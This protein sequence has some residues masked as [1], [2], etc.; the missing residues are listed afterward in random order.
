MLSLSIPEGTIPV[1]V[2]LWNGELLLPAHD[3]VASIL[4]R[5]R[6]ALEQI[7]RNPALGFSGA[8]VEGLIEIRGALV[9]ALCAVLETNLAQK[10]LSLLSRLGR[11]LTPNSV[12]QAR[13]NAIAHYDLGCDFF[14]LWLDETMTYSCAVFPQPEAPLAEAQRAKCDLICRKLALAPGERLL[15]VGCGWGYLGIH[16][17]R[18]YGVTTLGITQSPQQRDSAVRQSAEQGLA[19]LCRFELQDYRK[20]RGVFD[21]VASVGMLE[22]VGRRYLG[23]YFRAIAAALR[24]GGRFC[25]QVIGQLHP[26]AVTDFTNA[27]FPGGYIPTATEVLRHAA[28]AGLVCRHADNLAEHYVLTLRRWR[29]NFQ[30]AREKIEALKGAAFTRWWELHLAFSEAA[31]TVG[32]LHLFQFL[33]TKGRT[34]MPLNRGFAAF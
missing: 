17:A 30:T 2:R 14:R 1:E 28:E 25:L 8:Y 12:T 26:V 22:H 10:G 34:C 4:I 31:F 33:F 23:H 24:D 7:A 27:V 11:L 19:E 5:S 16:A 3:A 20:I 6:Q 18:R 21:K 32:R 9:P 15:D 29:E 13:R